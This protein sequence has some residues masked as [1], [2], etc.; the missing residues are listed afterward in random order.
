MSHW[1]LPTPAPQGDQ[2]S[3]GKKEGTEGKIPRE[4]K[5]LP[6]ADL[7]PTWI[8]EEGNPD[9]SEVIHVQQGEWKAGEDVAPPLD[10][11]T[12]SCARLR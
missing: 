6:W 4:A 3:K 5:R 7:K 9:V 1:P 12:L 11:E 2:D 8:E 10:D